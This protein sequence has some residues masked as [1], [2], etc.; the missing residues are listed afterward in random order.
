MF[1]WIKDF[2]NN[3]TIEVRVGMEFSSIYPIENG[4]PQGSVC[5]PMLFNIMINDIFNRIDQR[6]GRALYADDG[7]LWVRGR[8]IDNLK[9]KMQSAIDKV[10][11]WSYEW[12]F[13]LSIEKTQFICFSKKKNEPYYRS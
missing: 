10:E 6:M 11:K 4:T 2:L 8:N 5:S 1:N 13:H 7:A 9:V 3:R 12:G